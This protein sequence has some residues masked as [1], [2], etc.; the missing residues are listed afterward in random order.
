MSFISISIE[1]DP[2][3]FV[4][5]LVLQVIARYLGSAPR[6]WMQSYKDELLN[7]SPD[8]WGLDDLREHIDAFVD[9]GAVYLS[10]DEATQLKKI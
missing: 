3:G 7:Q 5:P 2:F 8:K 6:H 4:T 9:E 1:S 10:V